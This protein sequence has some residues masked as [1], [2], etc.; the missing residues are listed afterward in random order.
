MKKTF[1]TLIIPAYNE[2][3]IIEST[4][5]KV[6]NFLTKKTYSWEVIVVDDGS[7][8]GMSAIV[9]KWGA[10]NV[11]L[12]RYEEN[13]GKGGALKEGVRRAVGKYVIFSDADLS[14]PIETVDVLINEI[15]RGSQVAVG[16]RRAEGSEIVVHQPLFREYLGRVYT[17]LTRVVTNTKVSDFTCGFKGFT[18]D[19][20]KKVFSKSLLNRWAY[21]SEILF[22]AKKYGYGIKEVPVE[23]T[24]RGDS[25]VRVGNAVVTSLIDLLKIRVF[26]AFR[27]YD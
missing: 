9:K 1:L 19:A 4:L 6:V 23:W 2:K 25:R 22:L 13:R 18:N 12:I 20:A 10:K 11:S 17:F 14:V 26:E 24:D 7:T 15:K 3:K 5:K 21:D 8:D 27:K 16:T